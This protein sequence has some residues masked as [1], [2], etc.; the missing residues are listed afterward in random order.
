FALIEIV[1]IPL[2][3]IEAYVRRNWYFWLCALAVALSG[4]VFAAYANVDLENG[5][6]W[7]LQ[8]FFLLAH[9]ILAPVV[10]LGLTRALTLVRRL[11]TCLETVTATIVLNG[12]ACV[13][14]GVPL[15]RNYRDLDQSSNHIA[16][17]FARDVLRT[18]PPRSVLMALGDEVVLPVAY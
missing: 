15:L 7:L 2:G 11:A 16:R 14:V 4:P 1:L 6:L 12:A 10:A 5:G 8:R 13:L 3:L 17:D 18:L 9:V